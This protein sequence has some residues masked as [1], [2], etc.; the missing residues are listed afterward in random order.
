MIKRISFSILCLF[1]LASVASAKDVKIVVKSDR[2][3][4]VE[5]TILKF[6]M[7]TKTVCTLTVKKGIN[8]F[9]TDKIDER[10]IYHIGY[11][12]TERFLLA[13]ALIDPKNDTFFVDISSD[14]YLYDGENKG[15][16]ETLCLLEMKYKDVATEMYKFKDITKE[17]GDYAFD[18]YEKMLNDIQVQK[19]TNNDK[20]ILKGYV[21]G[22][23]LNNLY[24]SV[25]NSKV[26]GKIAKVTIDDNHDDCVS[27]MKLNRHI[28]L[29]PQWYSNVTEFFYTKINNG[30]LKIKGVNSWLTDIAKEIKDKQLRD[31]F[32]LAALKNNVV[33][34][35][36]KD[37]MILFGSAKKLITDAAVLA[38]VNE[39]ELKAQKLVN[40]NEGEY[41]G[42]FT[43]EDAEGNIAQLSKFKGKYV[44]ID[45]W[46]TG[47]NP[48]IGEMPYMK[49]IEHSHCS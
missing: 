23:L 48:C 47:C 26:F 3:E 4:D 49:K 28:S 40:I 30:T 36:S 31:Q 29:Y 5:F 27:G 35:Y 13:P 37:I 6:E 22:V 10:S 32:I 42:D 46:S 12:K 19:L 9:V 43:F 25:F 2:Q 11:R 33:M 8:E 41:L 21:Q 34:E 15:I 14:N 17:R 45:M 16:N 7:M 1:C 20:E 39:L 38:E 18:M 24:A 44:L